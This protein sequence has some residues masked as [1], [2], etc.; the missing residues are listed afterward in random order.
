MKN[1]KSSTIIVILLLNL[2]CLSLMSCKGPTIQGE[3]FDSKGKIAGLK[4]GLIPEAKI[5]EYLNQKAS[6][7]AKL[8][9]N[10]ASDEQTDILYLKDLPAPVVSTTSDSD[11]K[12]SLQPPAPG[13]Y[14]VVGNQGHY[15]AW[16]N[17][18]KTNKIQIT[19]GDT[20]QGLISWVEVTLKAQDL[21]K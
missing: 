9:Q 2:A 13:R 16:V 17:T 14:L 5:Q 15:L 10:G 6:E 12:F 3:A 7:V 4:I 1:L 20:Y 21:T 19:G 8:K 18:N 11:G